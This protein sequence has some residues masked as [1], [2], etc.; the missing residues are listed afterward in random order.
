M[1]SPSSN[2][3]VAA[4]SCFVSDPIAKGVSA[5]LGRWDATS[6]HPKITRAAIAPAD[7]IHFGNICLNGLLCILGG[8]RSLLDFFELQIGKDG[9][10]QIAYADNY[11]DFE[12][13]KKGH[14]IWAK[15]VG[16][17]SALER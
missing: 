1:R 16:G 6:A 17:R 4:V 2:K 8:D 10:A 12:D 3:I 13:G 9:M 7:P 15:Q 5:W 14:V 11:G